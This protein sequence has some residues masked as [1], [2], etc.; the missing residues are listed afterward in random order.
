MVTGCATVPPPPN[1]VSEFALDSSTNYIVEAQARGRLLRL[2]VDPGAPYFVLLN[3]K[4]AKELRLVSTKSATLAVGP[5]RLKAN[6]RNEK[7]TIRGETS[8]KPV[9]WVKGE[10]IPDADGV[11]NPAN[12]PGN[13]VTLKLREAAADEQVIQLPMR[14][15]RQRGLY[16][17]FD[18][19]GQ[20]ILTRFTLEDRL[21]TT[22]GAAASVISKRRSGLWEGGPFVHQVR[23]GVP[24]P[25]RRMVLGQTLSVKG[26][27]LNEFAVRVMDDRGS[28]LLPDKQVASEDADAD[29]TEGSGIVVT[30]KGKR[31]YG[32]AHFWLMV[33]S[34]ALSRCSSL[35]YQARHLILR[36][37]TART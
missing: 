15:D 10:A 4:V 11:I 35:T 22:T 16:Y 8:A 21:T 26:F 13:G 12:L 1:A 36:C 17:E 34:D 6:T 23:F 31:S 28:Y 33:G 18:Y 9:M 5:L 24:R 25:V 29:E 37:S 20:L 2:K 14:F 30:G 7:L 3:D 19:G 32:A 27:P